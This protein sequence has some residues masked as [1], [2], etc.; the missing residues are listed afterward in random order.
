MPLSLLSVPKKFSIP[1]YFLSPLRVGTE[2]GL[3]WGKRVRT[4]RRVGMGMVAYGKGKRGKKVGIDKKG[5]GREKGWEG[6]K[7]VERKKMVVT[8]K[9]G[10]KQR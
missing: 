1:K 2:K 9:G 6:Q 7:I 10:N 5:W 8:N 3:G 4:E